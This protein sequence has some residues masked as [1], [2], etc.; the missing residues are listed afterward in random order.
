MDE[1]ESAAKSPKMEGIAKQMASGSTEKDMI[2]IDLAP[3]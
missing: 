3:K 2:K 1:E